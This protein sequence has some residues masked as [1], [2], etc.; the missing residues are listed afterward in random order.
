M[1]R[2]LLFKINSETVKHHSNDGNGKLM[3]YIDYN[4]IFCGDLILNHGKPYGDFDHSKFA[5]SADFKFKLISLSH[6]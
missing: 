3:K 5:A 2:P 4:V 6:Y 1:V